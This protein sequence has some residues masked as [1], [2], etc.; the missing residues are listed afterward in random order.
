MGKYSRCRDLCDYILS[1]DDDYICLYYKAESLFKE[2]NFEAA[3]ECLNLTLSK[4]DHLNS[5][6]NSNLEQEPKRR[7]IDETTLESQ[8]RQQI[9]VGCL[10]NKAIIQLTS[11]DIENAFLVIFI[12]FPFFSFFL[13]FFDFLFLIQ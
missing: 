6:L 8:K 12:Y 5:K 13:F 9:T 2:Q 3:L 1:R 10:N 11:G 4:L 7:K